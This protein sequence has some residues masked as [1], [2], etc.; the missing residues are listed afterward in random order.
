MSRTAYDEWFGGSA[1]VAISGGSPT[2][3]LPLPFGAGGAR[4]F[5]LTVTT[6]GG[7]LRLPDVARLTPGGRPQCSIWHHSGNN[8]DV[9]TRDGVTLVMGGMPTGYVHDFYLMPD[10]TWWH[11]SAAVVAGTPYSA[12]PSFEL[13]FTATTDEGINLRDLIDAQFGYDGSYAVDLRVI[14]DGAVIGA[15]DRA[16]PAFRTGTW[17]TGSK[18]LL[19]LMAGSYIAGKGGAGGRGG[20]AGTGLLAQPGDAG[21]IGLAIEVDTNLLN[22]GTIAGGGGGGGG[23]ASWPYGYLGGGGDG[24]GGGAGYG[25]SAGG[26][27]GNGQYVGPVSNGDVTPPG[28][29]GL[30]GSLGVP[31]GVVIGNAQ[32]GTAPQS[33]WAG[34]GGTPGADGDVGASGGGAGG[35]AIAVYGGVTLTQVVVGT[36]LGAVI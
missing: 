21:G 7:V 35:A 5:D 6:A 32:H 25:Y 19:V 18:L 9:K 29:S 15:P 36:I 17:P 12:Q 4:L 24:G 31:G 27:G 28:N 14:L 26:R 23:G 1:A 10:G 34:G 3:Y 2:A 16:T 22:R 30:D 33:E 8:V 20:D 13:R 11:E